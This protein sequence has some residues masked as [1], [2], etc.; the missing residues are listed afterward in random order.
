[1]FSCYVL[2]LVFTTIYPR[3]KFS[4]AAW[5]LV[6]LYLVLS[7]LL[8]LVLVAH[9]T[10]LRDDAPCLHLRARGQRRHFP[11]H[12]P[13]SSLKAGSGRTLAWQLA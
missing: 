4:A 11:R 1:M 9:L 13:Q 5:T 12:L 7:N 6:I 8:D 2:L 10:S 3:T